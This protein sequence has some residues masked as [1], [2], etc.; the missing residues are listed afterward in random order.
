[1]KRMAKI[2][3]VYSLLCI[4]SEQIPSFT[5]KDLWKYLIRLVNESLLL[6]KNVASMEYLLMIYEIV[7]KIGSPFFHQLNAHYYSKLLTIIQKKILIYF[8]DNHPKKLLL[9]E[10][11]EK[12]MNSGGRE[13]ISLFVATKK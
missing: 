12:F 2:I 10:F 13:S 1:M 11:I 7:L 9:Q 8:P 3:T 4:Q 6:N 5:V